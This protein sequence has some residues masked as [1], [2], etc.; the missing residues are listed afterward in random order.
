MPNSVINLNLVAVYTLGLKDSSVE[1]KF[2]T[3]IISCGVFIKEILWK[4]EYRV[5]V[6]AQDFQASK[7]QV[8][9]WVAV[10]HKDWAGESMWRSRSGL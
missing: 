7:P 8:G 6:L 9:S 3:F 2:L 5:V 4:G 1:M 10:L